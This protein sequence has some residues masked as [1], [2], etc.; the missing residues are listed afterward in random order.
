MD[1]FKKRQFFS[2]WFQPHLNF[3]AKNDIA[4]STKTDELAC[5]IWLKL[6]FYQFEI[7]EIPAF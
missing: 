4:N 5:Q 1:F 6:K 3:P 2:D 7:L